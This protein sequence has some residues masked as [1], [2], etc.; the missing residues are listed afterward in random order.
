MIK[1]IKQW[2][3]T[4]G[5]AIIAYATAPAMITTFI[6][7]G[8][9]ALMIGKTM[10]NDMLEYLRLS[11]YAIIQE[12]A[13]MS[14]D[15]TKMAVVT[16]LLEDFKEVNESDIT[17]FAYDEE[18]RTLVRKFSTIPNA[19]GT[20]IDDGIYEALQSGEIYSAK[21]ANVNGIK[22]YAWYEPVMKDGQCVGAI[23]A[24]QPASNVDGEI[25]NTMVT[26]LKVG[27]GV[28][29]VISAFVLFR[30]R[31]IRL[32]L[33]KTNKVV[34]DLSM[35]DLS[36][37]YEI[38]EN[39]KDEI[40]TINNV[41]ANLV[42]QLNIMMNTTKGTVDTL[43]DIAENLKSSAELTNNASNEIAK[44][45]TDV[46]QG[47]NSQAE[48]TSNATL[49]VG[50][51]ADELNKIGINANELDGVARDMN[52]V[53]NTAMTVLDGLKKAN[54][55]IVRDVQNMNTQVGITSESVEKIQDAVN[56]IKEIADQTKLLSLNANIEAAR[57]GEAG[58][59]FS[60]VASSIGELAT[61]S[62]NSSE[63][64]EKI[65]KDLNKNYNLIED[66]M[67][68]TTTNV[69]Y[70]SQKI[71][72]TYDVFNSLGENINNTVDRV[73]GINSMI[74]IINKNIAEIVDIISNLSAISEENSASTQETMANIEQQAATI[75]QILDKA[76]R[77]AD[78]A[79]ELMEEV[80]IFKT[81]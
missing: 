6:S 30:V 40:E 45:I 71:N 56:V 20:K 27:V 39:P 8:V 59:G 62:A 14:A 15:N 16:D 64:I 22:Y 60:V 35:N 76:N 28:V 18:E 53:K 78:T 81:V 21:D 47:A 37:T 57:A 63:A 74:E 42:S 7:V 11:T 79:N 12:T 1:K 24:G 65:L 33:V 48:E 68:N 75:E 19:I 80:N 66:S 13:L 77:V 4:L 31:K 67:K 46:A 72:E 70:Q 36:N 55:E 29:L 52:A 38:Y 32:K 5:A 43:N 9:C 58:R 54:N 50:S 2:L 69:D 26:M 25:I 23:F 41:S 61:Q 34:N 3:H 44:A 17:I 51:V 10:K 49:M 73:N